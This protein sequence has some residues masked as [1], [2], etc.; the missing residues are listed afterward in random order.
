MFIGRDLHIWPSE[1]H[2]MKQIKD[3]HKISGLEG[4]GGR[5]CIMKRRLSVAYSTT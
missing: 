3:Q 5:R 2:N 4:Q 1:L